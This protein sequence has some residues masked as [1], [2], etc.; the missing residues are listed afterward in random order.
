MGDSLSPSI[1]MIAGPNGAG[2]STAAP[3]LLRGA[4]GVQ[5]FVNADVIA[6]GLSAFAPETVDAEA[7]LGAVVAPSQLRAG[8]YSLRS[9]LRPLDSEFGGNRLQVLTGLFLVARR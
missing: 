3:T 5:E 2:K 6:R 9:S 8:D 7:S 4:L 1:V